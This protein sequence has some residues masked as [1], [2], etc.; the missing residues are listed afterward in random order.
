MSN[1]LAITNKG[2]VP[3][4][5]KYRPQRLKNVYGLKKHQKV[6]EGYIAK[7]GMPNML[8]IGPSGTGK[9]LIAEALCVEFGID[10]QDVLTLNASEERGIETIRAK[11]INFGKTMKT[12]VSPFKVVILDEGDSLTKPAQQALR[13]VMEDYDHVRFIITGNDIGGISKALQS[14]CSVMQF[15]GMHY[16]VLQELLQ[17]I[18]RTEGTTLYDDVAKAIRVRCSGDARKAINLLESVLMLDK[19]TEEDVA[20]LSGIPSEA[21]VWEVI[22]GALKGKMSALKKYD[23]MVKGGE[24][25]M[26]IAMIMYYGAVRGSIRGITPKQQLLVLRAI[27]SV[28]MA[29]AEQNTAAM[30]GRLINLVGLKDEEEEEE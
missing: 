6:L 25:P 20:E 27:G 7:G 17:D 4:V 15:R 3:L 21:N 8:F 19:P 23:E 9:T 14:R 1:V 11:V 28:P 26:Q 13:K 24:D 18:A 30:I 16:K 2:N 29:T 22:Y 10:R 12:L 5:T